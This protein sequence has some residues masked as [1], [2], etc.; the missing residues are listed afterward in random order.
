MRLKGVIVVIIFFSWVIYMVAFHLHWWSV[1]SFSD[2]NSVLI[3]ESMIKLTFENRSESISDLFKQ[4]VYDQC[5]SFYPK[6]NPSELLQSTNRNNTLQDI[7]LLLR[8]SARVDDEHGLYIQMATSYLISK[9]LQRLS[10]EQ[11][12]RARVAVFL[13]ENYTNI[14]YNRLETWFKSIYDPYTL[15][16]EIIRSVEGDQA[17]W[18]FMM[19]Y[20]KF[21]KEIHFETI[22]FLL[23]NEYIFEVDMLSDT[24]EFF[25][26]YDP[27][28][29]HQTDYPDRC[30]LDMNDNNG[31]LLAPGRTRLWRSM[32]S[33]TIT[34]ACRLKTFLAF[35]DILIDPK[36]DWKTSSRDIRGRVGNTAVFCAVP[37]YSSHIETLLLPS[38]VNITVNGDMS[39]Y[40]KDWWSM[41]RRALAEAQKKDSFPAP[42]IDE[43]NLFKNKLLS[44]E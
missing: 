42:K 34:Y 28:F 8:Y 35:E 17:S 24:I 21:N 4:T 31:F 19:N 20:T 40:Y 23:E 25:T 26:S 38:D 9:N 41:A 6:N 29:V 15:T 39:A 22:L 12:N 30:R 18:E 3:T 44:I 32:S 16:T 43:Q 14:M 5:K 27:C 2:L 13:S 36:N 33:T 10:I 7:Y 11:Q 1:D 37:S